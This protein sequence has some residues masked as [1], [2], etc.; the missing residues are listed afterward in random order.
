MSCGI[1]SKY[2]DA[3]CKKLH[4]LAKKQKLTGRKARDST[5]PWFRHSY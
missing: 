5:L 2:I 4:Q 1:L 3:H